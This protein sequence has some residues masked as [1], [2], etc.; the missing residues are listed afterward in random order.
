MFGGQGFFGC[1]ELPFTLGRESFGG[2][3]FGEGSV[4]LGGVGEDRGHAAVTGAG[5]PALVCGVGRGVLRRFGGAG[6]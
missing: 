6:A 2:C 1:V 5:A 4:S 3:C